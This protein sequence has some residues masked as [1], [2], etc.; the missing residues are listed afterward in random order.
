M[1]NNKLYIVQTIYVFY[2]YENN[3]CR[4]KFIVED[5]EGKC[6]FVNDVWSGFSSDWQIIKGKEDTE[7]SDT[8]IMKQWTTQKDR[9]TKS[10]VCPV[11]VIP[12]KKRWNHTLFRLYLLSSCVYLTEA[13][14]WKINQTWYF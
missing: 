10:V 1:Y 14:C 9:K 12:H 5:D 4:R 3:I 8:F 13:V 6:T 2:K 11:N 7:I